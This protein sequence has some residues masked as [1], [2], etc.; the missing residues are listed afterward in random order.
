MTRRVNILVSGK[1]QGV[2]FRAATQKQAE[3]LAVK[4]WVRNLATGDVEILAVGEQSAIAQLIRWCHQG[5][6]FAR[7]AE[8]QVTELAEGEDFA[9]FD[10]RRDNF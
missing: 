6:T 4:G 9:D 10:I 8:V 5:P 2:C 3:K 7:V 1:V